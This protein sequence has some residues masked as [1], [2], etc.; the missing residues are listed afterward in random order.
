MPL[1]FMLAIAPWIKLLCRNALDLRP[2]F[3]S[4]SSHSYNLFLHLLPN[5]NGD[6]R[7]TQSNS[8]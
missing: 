6:K 2:K 1:L 4:H 3:L 8:K 5:Y 7:V